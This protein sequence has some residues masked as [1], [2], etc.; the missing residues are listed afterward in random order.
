MVPR[1]FPRKNK[2]TAREIKACNRGG[3]S[4]TCGM[5]KKKP[6]KKVAKKKKK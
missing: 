3:I 4:R 1:I 6:A 5:A 2:I